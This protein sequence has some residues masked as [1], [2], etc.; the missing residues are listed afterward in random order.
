[1]KMKKTRIIVGC[2]FLMSIILGGIYFYK[3]QENIDIEGPVLQS[4]LDA[5]T[6]SIQDTE[7]ELIEG[8]TAKDDRD[9]DIS[10]NILIENIEKKE[11]GADN[12]FLAT[13]VAFD[14][15]NNSGRLTRTLY[16]EDYRQTHFAIT[17]P[18]RF[19]QN[20]QLS[21]FDYFQADDCIDGDISP[22]ITLE[23]DEEI[24]EKPEKGIYDCKLSIT[25]SV[26]D[27]TELPIQ[28]EI[29]ED[30]YEERTFRPRIVLTEYIVYLKQGEVLDANA[31]LDH[32]EDRGVHLLDFNTADINEE[33]TESS[34]QTSMSEGTNRV[35]ISQI[36]MDSNVNV[37]TPGVYSVVYSYTSEG[38]GYNCNTNLIVVVE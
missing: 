38:T 34:E 10:D 19:P 30:G 16:Y 4:A 15:A 18:L 6:V 36:E 24:L 25:N 37:N 28:V 26:G 5:I 2:I 7:K 1:M 12:E 14:K 33:D 3:A 27:I 11:G 29:Y 35:S 31:Y 17:Q 32:V 9:G 20:Q 8:I 21:L 13:C 22:F 23:G